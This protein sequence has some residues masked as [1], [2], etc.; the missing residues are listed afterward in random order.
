[1]YNIVMNKQCQWYVRMYVGLGAL[2]EVVEHLSVEW[3]LSMFTRSGMA[4]Q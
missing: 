3:K 1:M 4:N 2:L